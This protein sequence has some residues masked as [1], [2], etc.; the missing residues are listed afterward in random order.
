MVRSEVAFI[1]CPFF[2]YFKRRKHISLRCLQKGTTMFEFV[3]NGFL[4]KH[5][6]SLYLFLCKSLTIATSLVVLL[7][8][9]VKSSS[10]RYWQTVNVVWFVQRNIFA[11]QTFILQSVPFDTTPGA[12][13]WA[14]LYTFPFLELVLYLQRIQDLTSLNSDQQL[15][16]WSLH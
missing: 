6:K 14:G 10:H 15:Y 5:N 7:S 2:V 3:V 13:S 12:S 9:S 4:Q 8:F 1:F 16:L 11:M